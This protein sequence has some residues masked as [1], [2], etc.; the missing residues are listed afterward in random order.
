[1]TPSTRRASALR[2]I[3]VVLV[4]T[5]VLSMAVGGQAGPQQPLIIKS[6]AGRDLFDFY[7][8]TCHGRDAKG[9]G[10]TAKALRVPP[11]DLTLLTARNGGVF[12]DSRVE[13]LIADGSTIV[14]AHGSREMPIWAPIFSGLDP[15][16]H[17]NRLR[18]RNIVDF[19]ASIQAK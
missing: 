15:N 14:P 18:L 1:M 16:D 7:C 17:L 9:T 4:G 8:A 11:P 2:I 3:V 5:G 19:L 13:S 10:P 6:L 12:P